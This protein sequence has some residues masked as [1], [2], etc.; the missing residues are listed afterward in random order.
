MPVK[1]T[2]LQYLSTSSLVR[3]G[4]LYPVSNRPFRFRKEQIFQKFKKKSSP[5]LFSPPTSFH[6]DS[7]C[8]K[9]SDRCY[10]SA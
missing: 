6:S 10:T 5:Q 1:F 4:R 3:K 9:Y 7:V 8:K 2:P